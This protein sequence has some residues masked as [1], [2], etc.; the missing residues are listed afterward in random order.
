VGAV[1]TF[2]ELLAKARFKEARI[3]EID[4]SGKTVINLC[5]YSASTQDFT[6][7]S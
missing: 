5:R 2:D 7:T 1:G 6:I 3:K 4:P